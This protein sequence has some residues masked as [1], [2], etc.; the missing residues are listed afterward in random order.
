MRES[1][2]EEEAASLRQI[3]QDAGEKDI[4]FSLHY[5]LVRFLYQVYMDFFF[6]LLVIN[7]CVNRLEIFHNGP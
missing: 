7:V 6:F 3:L 1:V 4:D 5:R 2:W